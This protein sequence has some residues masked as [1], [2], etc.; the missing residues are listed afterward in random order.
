[1][2]Q[3]EISVVSVGRVP[4]QPTNY[5]WTVAGRRI[6]PG[7]PTRRVPLDVGT[8]VMV[9]GIGVEVSFTSG[10]G[11]V[12][13]DHDDLGVLTR[14]EADLVDERR[15]RRDDAGVVGGQDSGA[16]LAR[17]GVVDS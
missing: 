17:A 14:E 1:M 7:G 12:R 5:T 8:A 9:I 6:R 11:P 13:S 10:F 3:D 16:D 15:P 4:T 2:W